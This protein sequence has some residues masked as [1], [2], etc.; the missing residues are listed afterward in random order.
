MPQPKGAASETSCFSLEMVEQSLR[1]V[2]NHSA[3]SKDLG[4]SSFMQGRII[5]WRNHTADYH[6]DVWATERG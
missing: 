3:W 2:G 5:V 6:Q 4:G 1:G